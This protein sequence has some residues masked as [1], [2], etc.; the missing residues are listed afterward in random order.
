MPSPGCRPPAQPTAPTAQAAEQVAGAG[1]WAVAAAA[2]L[3]I[4]VACGIAGLFPDY[5][6]NTS[7]VRQPDELVPHAIY[8]AVWSASALLILLGGRRQRAGALLGMGTSIVTFGLFFAD[9]GT[10]IAGGAHLMGVGLVL[11]LVGWLACSAGSTVAFALRREGVGFGRPRGSELV[12]FLTFSLA[13]LGVAA[14]FAPSWDSY[15]LQTSAG[16]TESLTAGNVFSNP[17]PVIAGN[18]AVM[19]AFVAVV[20]AAALWRPLLH[21]GV[22]L[23]GAVIPMAAQAVSAII[24]IGEH[25]SPTMFGISSS[26]A[27]QSGLTITS[28]LTLAFWIY[29]AFVV[30]LIVVGASAVGATR[31][32]EPTGS[33]QAPSAQVT[34]HYSP[35]IPTV[36]P[37][38]SPVGPEPKT[39]SPNAPSVTTTGPGLPGGDRGAGSSD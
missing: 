11:G 5:L 21:G 15:V 30:V 36:P 26:A 3:A 25:T 16:T 9:S 31:P 12:P 23:A 7:L 4:G 34:G 29:C 38:T 28:G 13:A 19:V 22:L 14:A 37:G 27:A 32:L 18:V 2:F 35:T 24:Q 8:F 33:P 10:A 17:A 20:V 1:R 39:A 6:N